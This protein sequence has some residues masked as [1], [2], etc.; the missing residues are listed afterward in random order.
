MVRITTTATVAVRTE[1]SK[2]SV[3]GVVGPAI[4]L[5]L[6]SAEVV[7]AWRF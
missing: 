6:A 4:R 1:I 3:S 2:L 5:L 7:L